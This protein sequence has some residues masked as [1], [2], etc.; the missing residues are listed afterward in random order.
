MA[1]YLWLFALVFALLLVDKLYE[2][3][4]LYNAPE[5]DPDFS[6]VALDEFRLWAGTA[7]RQEKRDYINRG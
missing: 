2:L 5:W 1:W 6:D 7:T 4:M 3:Y